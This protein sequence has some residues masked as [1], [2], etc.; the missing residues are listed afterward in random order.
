MIPWEPIAGTTIDG[1]SELRLWRRGDEY[2]IR[3][4]PQE[5]MNSRVHGSEEALARHACDPIAARKAPRVLVGG[6]GMGYTL[7]AA[8]RVLPEDARVDVVELAPAVIDWNRDLLGHLAGHPLRDPRVAVHARDVAALIAT[9]AATFDAILLDVD[10][11]PAGLAREENDGLYSRDGLAAAW[12]ALRPGGT[13]AV[14]SAGPDRAF[15]RRL[16]DAG[17]AVDTRFVRARG[18]GKGGWHALWVATRPERRA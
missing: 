8:L 16:R 17:F 11:G 2:A 12:Q 18:H 14:W 4:G 9:G 3:I 15:Q 1:G 13:L 6:L 10:N 5:L 7:A